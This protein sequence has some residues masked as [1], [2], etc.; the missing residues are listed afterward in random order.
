MPG[1]LSNIGK[2]VGAPFKAVGNGVL[3]LLSSH[4]SY[5]APPQ[6]P[7]AM[8]A[9]KVTTPPIIGSLPS[10]TKVAPLPPQWVKPVEMAYQK[11]PTVPKGLVEAILHQESSMGSNDANYNPDIGESAWL[12]GLTKGAKEE[13]ARRSGQNPDFDSQEGVINALAA[14]LSLVQNRHDSTGKVVKTIQDPFELYN[15]Y[16][17]TE[18]GHSLTKKQQKDFKDLVAHYAQSTL[19]TK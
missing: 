9:P 1:L 16:Y 13:I 6:A 10:G 18:S 2:A 19:A 17:K 15:S 4:V 5:S 3:D 8:V 7:A 12:A 11:Y 14:Y